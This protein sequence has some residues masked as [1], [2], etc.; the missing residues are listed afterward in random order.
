MFISECNVHNFECVS[1]ILDQL[2]QMLFSMGLLNRLDESSLRLFFL[3]KKL[4][5]EIIVLLD[6]FD[7]SFW[8]PGIFK[9]GC[10]RNNC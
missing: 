3:I 1:L 10:V 6:T 7:K 2:G 8:E 4:G 9:D 5:R